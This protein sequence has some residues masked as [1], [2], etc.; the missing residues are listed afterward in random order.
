[1][2][3]F[4]TFYNKHYLYHCLIYFTLFT[5]KVSKPECI[6]L[7]K[8]TERFS[9]NVF[10]ALSN[11]RCFYDGFLNNETKSLGQDQSQANY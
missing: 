9:W 11:F 10:K 3:N 6:M 4:C 1:M 2:K 7:G 8:G 5:V